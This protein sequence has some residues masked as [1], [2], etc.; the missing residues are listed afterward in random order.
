MDRDITVAV[1]GLNATDNPG[2]GVSVIRALRHDPTFRGR[3]V[4]LAYDSL[5]PGIY[6]RDLVDDVFLV[7]YPSQGVEALADR[8]AY[9][10]EAV[11][12]DAIIPTLDSELP[13]FI[14]LERELA[15]RGIATFLPTRE[16]FDLRA[17]S[18]LVALGARSGIPVPETRVLSDVGELY[19]IHRELEFPL[20]IKGLFYGATVAR[21]IDEAVR[22][23]HQVVAQW[24]FPAMAQAFVEG[25]ELNVAAVGDGQGGLVGAVSMRKTYLTD[26]GK[27]WAGITIRDPELLAL[28]RRFVEASSW[29]GPFEVEVVKTRDRGY[30]LLEV[31]PR[32]P[33][34]IY[35][36]AGAGLN[37]PAALLRLALGEPTAPQSDYRVGVMFVRISLDQIADLD[38]LQQLATSGE[39][40]RAG[41]PPR[42]Q[43]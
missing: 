40:R 27:G 16:Q 21:S 38:D 8:L 17:K 29:R 19:T 24:G 35:L 37:L 25:D 33:A 36:S 7:P 26:K 3:V 10:H 42:E 13:D 11:G 5:E 6:A 34:W 41:G 43:P 12:L 23:Y 2:P 15:E 30:F 28:T 18:R 4:G 22:A 39:L 20:V 32:F 1:T 31:N 9:V 14:A